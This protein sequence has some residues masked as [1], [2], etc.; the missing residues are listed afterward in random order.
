MP[1]SGSYVEFGASGIQAFKAS[2]TAIGDVQATQI[3]VYPNPATNM[4]NVTGIAAETQISLTN[5][6]GQVVLTR[7]AEA[8]ASVQIDISNLS[9]GVYLLQAK[10]ASQSFV[11]KIFVK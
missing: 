2:A 11:Q 6:Q 3:Q 9:A 10:D 4:V 1:N 5:T 8:G 7:N